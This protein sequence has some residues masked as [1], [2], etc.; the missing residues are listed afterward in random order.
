[1]IA[2]IIFTGALFLRL[3]APVAAMPNFFGRAESCTATLTVTIYSS[4]DESPS[5][6]SSS[7]KITSSALGVSPGSGPVTVTV[8]DTITIV[9]TVYASPSPGVQITGSPNSGGPHTVTVMVTNVFTSVETKTVVQTQTITQERT[10]V[11]TQTVTQ[12]LTQAS[13]VQTDVDVE[14]NEDPDGPSVTYTTVTSTFTTTNTIFLSPGTGV[15]PQPFSRP[16]YSNGTETGTYSNLTKS[17]F[18][19]PSSPTTSL[20]LLD[21]PP[22]STTAPLASDSSSS[23]P[24]YANVSSSNYENALYFVNWSV[25]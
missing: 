7:P 6:S 4:I 19:K 21:L 10:I 20:N 24:S 18:A 25:L 11:Q 12:T 3:L 13:S 2:K 8:V 1:M 23:P 15:P 16:L 14:L 22:E 5:P 17:S 9:S